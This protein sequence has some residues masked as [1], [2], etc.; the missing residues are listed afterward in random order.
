VEVLGTILMIVRRDRVSTSVGKQVTSRLSANRMS[1]VTI[2]E[3]QV[4]SVPSVP[5]RR[6]WRVRCSL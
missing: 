5:N 4:I 2:L 1:L 3:G 6:R